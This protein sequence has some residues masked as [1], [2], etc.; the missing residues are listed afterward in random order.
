MGRRKVALITAVWKRHGLTDLVLN[1][2]KNIKQEIADNIDLKLIAVGSE[3]EKSKKLCENHGFKYVEQDNMPLN[4]KYNAA[5][6]LAKETNPEAVYR[7]DSDDWIT[8]EAITNSLKMIDA[9]HSAVGLL[10]LYF[11]DLPT[12]K[13]GR[14]GGYSFFNHT[15]RIWA[16]R[17]KGKTVGV[18]RCFSRELMEVLDWEIWDQEPKL[19]RWLDTNCD[20]RLKKKG[21]KIQGFTMQQLQTFAMDIKGSGENITTET[22]SSLRIKWVEDAKLD[23]YK[24][25]PKEEVDAL[26]ALSQTLN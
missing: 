22:F 8:S 12:L 7:I 17:N 23:L 19:S 25:F 9:G 21:H 6:R 20:E 14:W 5:S 2:F 16:W 24:H 1:R 11:F 15:E 26:I 3:G 13:L 10:D 4:R 18:G